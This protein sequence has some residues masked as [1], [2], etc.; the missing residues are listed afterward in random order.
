MTGKSILAAANFNEIKIVLPR[1][2][3]YQ[4]AG[5]FL[6]GIQIGARPWPNTDSNRR[7]LKT[8]EFF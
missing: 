3:S 2:L 8:I 4:A 1:L 5:L 7:H 6:R